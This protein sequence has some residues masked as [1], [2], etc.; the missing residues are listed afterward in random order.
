LSVIMLVRPQPTTSNTSS[1]ASPPGLLRAPPPGAREQR[2]LCEGRVTQRVA[3]APTQP[4]ALALMV[5]RAKR[6]EADSEVR[7]RAGKQRARLC[8][9]WARWVWWA[10]QRAK[11]LSMISAGYHQKYSSPPPLQGLDAGVCP[12]DPRR[13]RLRVLPSLARVSAEVRAA[14]P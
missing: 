13:L 4:V 6:D 12:S 3:L 9:R 1:S 10:E 14:R 11:A 2:V 7:R 5:R 8:E